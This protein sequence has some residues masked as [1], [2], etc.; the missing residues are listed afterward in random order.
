MPQLFAGFSGVRVARK[1]AT[2]FRPFDLKQ[3]KKR[4]AEA[5]F[6]LA[7]GSECNSCRFID[8]GKTMTIVRDSARRASDPEL[9]KAI[10]TQNSLHDVLRSLFELLEEY[11]PVWYKKPYHDQAKSALNLPLAKH[12]LKVK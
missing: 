8:P 6:T 4:R 11:S 12:K 7:T 2:D 10:E 1:A 9:Q 5:Q 3:I